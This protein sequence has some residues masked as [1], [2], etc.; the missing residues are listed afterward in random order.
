[1]SKFL[2]LSFVTRRPGRGRGLN[3]WS[4]TPEEDYAKQWRQGGLL[5]LEALTFMA[6][7]RPPSGDLLTHVA[8]DMPR[9][10]ERTGVEL[11]FLKTIG[12][13]AVLARRRFGDGF[14]Q[15]RLAESDAWNEEFLARMASER[16]EQAKRAARTRRANKAKRKRN[17]A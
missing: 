15:T 1:M 11:G 8:L 3:Y 5:A 17:T 4:V 14:F 16:S 13:F 6:N 12:E 2:S 10:D 9:C 7:D